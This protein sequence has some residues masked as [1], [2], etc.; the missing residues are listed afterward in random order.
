MRK[1]R[2]V[3]IE[4][5]KRKSKLAKDICMLS[6]IIVIIEPLLIFFLMISNMFNENLIFYA[7]VIFIG[8]LLLV[9]MSRF[10]YELYMNQMVQ[11][12][13]SIKLQFIKSKCMKKNSKSILNIKNPEIQRAIIS[14]GIDKIEIQ[15]AIVDQWVVD[16]F[17]RNGSCV[18]AQISVE[19]F[20]TLL[21]DKVIE[22]LHDSL[23]ESIVLESMKN[24]KTNVKIKTITQDGYLYNQELSDEEL[25][26][27]I[28]IKS[29]MPT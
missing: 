19:D 17:L 4:E 7:S 6:V 26:Q 14:K 5:L 11:K 27:M 8:M 1:N 9:G 29:K 21:N 18:Q 12:R 13:K 20:I 28:E 16:I 22:S 10:K 15:K 24:G 2:K 3:T 23:T 25:L